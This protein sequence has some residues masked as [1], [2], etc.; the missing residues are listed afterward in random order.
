MDKQLDPDVLRF[1]KISTDPKYS[2][3]MKHVRIM[4]D[5]MLLKPNEAL[6]YYVMSDTM[7][8][9]YRTAFDMGKSVP[10]YRSG[11][12]GRKEAG[13]VVNVND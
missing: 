11:V 10:P 6:K 13:L 4:M 1:I 2:G 8:T 9:F 3:E 7:R 12:F 5:G